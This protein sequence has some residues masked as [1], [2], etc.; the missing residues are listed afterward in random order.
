MIFICDNAE[1]ARKYAGWPLSPMFAN[2]KHFT[3]CNYFYIVDH[4]LNWNAAIKL[5]RSDLTRVPKA[6]NLQACPSLI[7]AH[8]HPA[9]AGRP[10]T[11]HVVFHWLCTVDLPSNILLYLAMSIH[12]SIH[13]SIYPSIHPS[14]HASIHRSIHPSMQPSIHPSN[15]P[16]NPS[17]P[18]RVAD[19]CRVL[20]PFFSSRKRQHGEQFLILALVN[21]KVFAICKHQKRRNIFPRSLSMIVKYRAFFQLFCANSASNKF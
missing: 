6:A 2:G 15:Y 13:P 9:T 18:H 14:I 16:M 11:P 8:N 20:S 17:I 21:C 1:G 12:P 19:V 10:C 7:F 5:Q 3:S 4:H